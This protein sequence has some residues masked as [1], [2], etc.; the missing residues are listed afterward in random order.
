M[1][2]YFC[3]KM[4]SLL[5]LFCFFFASS[6]GHARE[7]IDDHAKNTDALYRTGAGAKDGAYTATSTSMIAWSALIILGIVLV[8]AA[9]H[10]SLAK[11]TSSSSSTDVQ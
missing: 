11:T 4:F 2:R 3:T 9:A 1:T 7:S 5:T 10:Q 8:V 6:V